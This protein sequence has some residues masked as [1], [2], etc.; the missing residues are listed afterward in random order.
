MYPIPAP[1]PLLTLLLQAAHELQ[2]GLVPRTMHARH[3]QHLPG[4]GHG[5]GQGSGQGS[6]HATSSI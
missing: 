5:M 1:H 3:Q 6:T 4:H 2:R